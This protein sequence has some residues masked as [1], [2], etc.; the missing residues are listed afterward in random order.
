M[1]KSDEPRPLLT[2]LVEQSLPGLFVAAAGVY[3]SVDR[4]STQIAELKYV[5]AE[6]KVEIKEIRHDLYSPNHYTEE[7]RPR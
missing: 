1:S 6:L 2:R 4:Q 3:V 5:I 7:A